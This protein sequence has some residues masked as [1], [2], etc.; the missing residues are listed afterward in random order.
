MP[1]TGFQSH[2]PKMTSL[3]LVIAFILL[4]GLGL[5]TRWPDP[6]NGRV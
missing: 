4:G 5:F 6:S 1:D 3:A 2:P